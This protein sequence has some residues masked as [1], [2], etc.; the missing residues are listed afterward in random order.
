MRQCGQSSDSGVAIPMMTAW[1]KVVALGL[2][3]LPAKLL[4]PFAYF[5]IKDKVNHPV[6]GVQDATDLSWWN[7][8]VRN[9]CHNMITIDMPDYVSSG[10]TE[11]ETLERLDGFQWRHRRSLDGKYVSFRMTWGKP[12][13][14]KGKREFYVGWTMNEMPYARLTFFQLRVW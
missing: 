13:S 10:N 11:D 12:R 6:F 7:I 1:L 3:K 14:N 8:G 2:I 5:L 9:A 4:A